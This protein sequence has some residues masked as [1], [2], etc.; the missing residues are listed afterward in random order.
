V[1]EV[2]VATGDFNRY[3]YKYTPP[4]PLGEIE[5]DIKRVEQEIMELLR[6]VTE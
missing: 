4:R 3:F 6:E 2:E 1:G 5:A